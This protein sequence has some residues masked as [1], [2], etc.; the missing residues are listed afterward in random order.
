MKRR[1][2]GLCVLLALITPSCVNIQENLGVSLESGKIVLRYAA[3]RPGQRLT[4]IAVARP[5]G[6]P[7]WSGYERVILWRVGTRHAQRTKFQVGVTPPG[8][9]EEV[10][11]ERPLPT[12]GAL[13]VV[14]D[15]TAYRNAQ[16]FFSLGDLREELIY[17]PESTGYVTVREFYADACD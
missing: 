6:E 9:E 13:G 7:P 4:A 10:P 3:C 2:A 12:T 17:R 5:L 16:Y 8:F 15:T 1:V 14:I 11:L